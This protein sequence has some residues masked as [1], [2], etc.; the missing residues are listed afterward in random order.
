MSWRSVGKL[1]KN[2]V[3]T[4]IEIDFM[5]DQEAARRYRLNSAA[6]EGGLLE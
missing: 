4:L 1:P 3:L 2:T 5:T 6:A